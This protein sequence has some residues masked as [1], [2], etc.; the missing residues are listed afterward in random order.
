MD[1]RGYFDNNATTRLCPEARLAWTEAVDNLWLNPSS[2]YRAAAKVHVQLEATRQGVADLFD[3]E[4]KRVVFNSGGT[5]GNN[6][7][8]A[9]WARALPA[10]AQI[11]VSPTE[12]PSVIEAAKAHFPN[13]IVWLALDS[14]GAVDF[15]AFSQRLR[16]GDFAAVSVMAANNET[17]ILN[18]W[19]AIADACGEHGCSFHCDATQWVGKLPLV[20]L[21]AC[22]FVTVCAHKF[23]GPRG[24]GFL[25]IDAGCEFFSLLGG[26]QQSGN[27]GGT[28]DVAGILAMSAALKRADVG[29]SSCSS[30]GRDLFEESLFQALPGAQCIGRAIERLWNTASILLPE[31]AS[32]RWIRALEKR[33]FLVSSGSACSTGKGGPSHVL[34]AMAVCSSAMRRVVRV[35]SSADTTEAD[36][37]LLLEAIEDAY[38]AMKVESSNSSSSVI[39]I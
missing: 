32:E 37:I 5:E 15:E 10:D 14:N 34:S 11:A 16:S 29:S 33:G 9:H 35:S 8:F 2:P 17:G 25:L 23:G 7:V 39:S 36:W 28:E 6:M 19:R 20:G 18:P 27:R 3:C 30:A 4:A 24:V 21:S 13:R 22:D 26:E 12:H 38:Q 1:Q 31:F